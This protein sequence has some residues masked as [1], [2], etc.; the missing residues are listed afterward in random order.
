MRDS[1]STCLIAAEVPD[2]DCC[3]IFEFLAFE[4][5]ADGVDTTDDFELLSLELK[6]LYRYFH[7]PGILLYKLY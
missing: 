2:F 3:N 4:E 1:F 5:D 7:L 6:S